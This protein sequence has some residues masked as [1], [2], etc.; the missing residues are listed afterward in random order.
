MTP[1]PKC[2]IASAG[3]SLPRRELSTGL[4]DGDG[5]APQAEG[6]YLPRSG[7]LQV[8]QFYYIVYLPETIYSLRYQQVLYLQ[9]REE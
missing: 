9:L 3:G 7:W 6:V 8:R 5:E 1:S 2:A 4:S